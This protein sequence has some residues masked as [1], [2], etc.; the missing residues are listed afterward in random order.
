[1]H[2]FPMRFARSSE[3]ASP[4]EEVADRETVHVSLG[5]PDPKEL[6]TLPGFRATNDRGLIAAVAAICGAHPSSTGLQ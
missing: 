1:M 3:T 6:E 4:S 5:Q 2:V